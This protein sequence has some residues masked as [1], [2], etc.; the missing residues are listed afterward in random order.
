MNANQAWL[1]RMEWSAL[2]FVPSHSPH[3]MLNT[4]C[5]IRWT[6][7][8]FW[9][10]VWNVPSKSVRYSCSE[11]HTLL[12]MED[13]I[14]I[15]APAHMRDVLLWLRSVATMDSY[16]VRIRISALTVTVSSERCG[17]KRRVLGRF[18][19]WSWRCDSGDIVSDSISWFSSSR[20]Q[21]PTVD[22]E[23]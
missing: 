5:F 21:P 7:L 14:Y 19:S 11:L 17:C 23:T 8:Y 6:T 9:L 20:F 4:S 13:I 15:V 3:I 2:K 18:R 22:V 1:S 12:N 16:I 10:P